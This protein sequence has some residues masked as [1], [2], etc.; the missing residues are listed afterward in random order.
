MSGKAEECNWKMH[1]PRKIK[2]ILALIGLS[3]PS[4]IQVINA[5]LRDTLSVIFEILYC[6]SMT[7]IPGNLAKKLK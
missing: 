6:F 7:R 2:V 1:L 3:N 5:V 4:H